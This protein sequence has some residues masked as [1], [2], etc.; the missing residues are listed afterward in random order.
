[1]TH[2]LTELLAELLTDDRTEEQK[3]R[4]EGCERIKFAL[5]L[6]VGFAVLV[7]GPCLLIYLQFFT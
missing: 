4:D 2:P 3:R 7:D 6:I 5:F 1:M